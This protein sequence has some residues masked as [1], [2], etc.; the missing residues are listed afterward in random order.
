MIGKAHE[1]VVFGRRVERLGA[2]LA[3]ALPADVGS[4]LD[5]GCGDGQISCAVSDAHPKARV[6]GIDVLVRPKTAIPVRAYD[7][8]HFPYPD[9]SYDYVMMV[10]VLHHTED[11]LQVLAEAARVA[12]RGVLV[13]DHTKAGPFALP[14]LRLMD[15]V[16]NSRHGVD[17]PYNY[18]TRSQWLD[19]LDILALEELSWTTRLHL[20]S[21]PLNLLFERSLHFVALF[22]GGRSGPGPNFIHQDER[23]TD[24][25]GSSAKM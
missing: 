14:T 13:K 1:R 12:C 25:T 15:W 24:S 21:F 2:L 20:Y 8:Q 4:I 7:G 23:R 5:V 19:A 22:G 10:D 18:W 3:Q 9:D 17:L 16:G 6:E 11:P